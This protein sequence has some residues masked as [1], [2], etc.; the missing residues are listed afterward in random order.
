MRIYREKCVVS[1]VVLSVAMFLVEVATLRSEAAEPSIKSLPLME[2]QLASGIERG[3]PIAWNDQQVIML[4]ADGSLSEYE[5][6]EIRRHKVL[7]ET[8]QPEKAIKLRGQLQQE[9]GKRFAVDGGGNFA[10]VALPENIAT[11]TRRFSQLDKAFEYYF[12]TRGFPLRLTE[13]PLVGIVFPSQA[14]FLQYA[15]RNKIKLQPGTVGYYSPVT[16]RLY[17]YEMH[18][19]KHAE[20]EGL[21][22]VWHEAAH[23]I[24]FNRGIHQ[25]LSKPPLWMLEGLASVFEAPG[26]MA[27]RSTLD[28]SY[29]LN[30]SR[31]SEWKKLAETPDKMA[32]LFDSMIRD[33]RLFRSQPTQAYTIAWGVSLYLAERDSNHYMQYLQRLSKL[34][35]GEE[36]LD[37][38]RERDFHQAFNTRSM[39]LIKSADRFLNSL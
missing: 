5:P 2:L 21:A 9:F 28:S 4:R 19:S 36:Y 33:D 11:W 29:L 35:P 18:G 12:R 39:Q 8:F 16:N 14:E 23:Q 15:N 31:W 37:Q 7:D 32:S 17:L 6:S 30:Q 25:R 27:Q 13:F 22:T 10:I 26:L 38:A 24:A 3:L 34:R 1:F 20:L